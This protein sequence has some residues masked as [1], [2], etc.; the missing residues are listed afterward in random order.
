MKQQSQSSNQYGEK[1]NSQLLGGSFANCLF[2][3]LS[4]SPSGVSGLSGSQNAAGVADIANVFMHSSAAGGG[5]PNPAV[6]LI[7]VEFSRAFAGLVSF[8][9]QIYQG[10]TGSPILVTSALTLGKAY[11]ITAVGT[12]TAAQW[13][14]LGLQA[15]AVPAVGAT[16]VCT[17]TTPVTGTGAVQLTQASGADDIQG[18]GSPSATLN[19]TGGGTLVLAASLSGVV[20]APTDGAQ[21]ALQFQMLAVPG[22]QI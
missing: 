21:I 20:S 14:S 16:F 17:S 3:V 1:S 7:L 18:V 19:V 10:L 12:T 13:Q 15:G 8:A 2:N 4:S 9:G 11:V 22:P 6:G 5:N